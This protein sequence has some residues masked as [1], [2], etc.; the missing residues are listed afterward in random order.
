[1][2][3]ARR[4]LALAALSVLPVLTAGCDL[5]FPPSSLETALARCDLSTDPLA[6]W[7]S[8]SAELI[9]AAERGA[10]PVAS[11]RWIVAYRGD[12]GPAPLGATDRPALP[13]A[14]PGSAIARDVRR[15][16]GLDLARSIAPGVE[17]IRP[18]RDPI[19]TARRLLDDERVRYVHPDVALRPSAVGG[20]EFFGEQWALRSF[21]VPEAWQIEEGAAQ[22]VV[23][24]IDTGFDLDH[25]DLAPRF[26]PGWDFY[27]GDGDPSI[28][29]VPGPP[30]HGTHVAGIIA[31]VG[32]NGVGVHGVAP[33]GVRLLPIKVFDDAG[34]D[35]SADEV[36]AQDAV[37]SAL[38]WI[39]GRPVDGPPTRSSPVQ[40]ANLS[41]GS[42]G[43]YA[44]IPALDDAVRVA[45][46][47]GVLVLAASGNEGGSAGVISPANGPCAVAIGSV[48][49]DLGLS[50]FSNYDAD[51]RSVDLVGP[52]GQSDGEPVTGVL[53]TIPD[54]T[55]GYLQGTSM[56]TP[57]AAGVA[58]LLASRN[59]DWTAEDLLGT[60]LGRAWLP[61]GGTPLQ[62]GFG[63]PCPDALLGATTVCGR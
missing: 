38:H 59:P 34:G 2:T 40:I 33:S 14:A 57:F 10:L 56:S 11:D 18:S 63:I 39:A 4:F 25:P 36:S 31:A 8:S 41:L 45:R 32:G 23:A 20:D 29:T 5:L 58:A 48:D 50:R 44:Q 27:Q 61:D 55:Y 49:E 24:V 16:Y 6:A 62:M 1:M 53:S 21:G 35:T 52:G 12:A 15:A 43:S 9:D 22:V 3:L 47:A 17:A 54:D 46:R 30:V 37:V 26:D 13:G 60:M 51:A 7:R 19:A 42:A 28:G